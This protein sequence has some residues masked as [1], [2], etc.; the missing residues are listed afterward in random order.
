MKKRG[1]GIAA[2]FYPTGMAGGGDFSHAIVKVKPDG[3]ADLII[4]TSELGQGALTV[5]AQMAAEVL[6]IPYAHVKVTNSDTDACPICFGSFA[7]RV[8]SYTGNAVVQAA[9]NARNIFF[10]VAAEL[11]G[12]AADELVAADGVVAVR[13]Q[14]GKT[15]TIEEVAWA[16]TFTYQKF[17]VGNGCYAPPFVRPDPATG[18]CNPLAAAL[19]FCATQVEIEVDTETGVIEVI[20]SKSV[21]DVGRAINPALVDGQIVGGAA[22]GTSWA[23]M[24]QLYPHYPSHK[25]QARSFSDYMIA[26]AM[27]VP[28]LESR[29]V[30]CPSDIGPFGAKGPGEMV[31]NAPSPAIVNAVRDALGI[32]ITD[33]PLTP[34][35]V[36]RALE[37]HEKKTSPV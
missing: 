7:S 23:L 16:A 13:G 25:H 28:K 32:W 14:P 4:G 30:E 10:E 3:T 22:M 37:E 8:T 1:K 2:G 11:L 24:E 9:E 26:T 12:C 5:L 36:L 18:E 20:D 35:K 29:I 6:G 21:Y 33:I 27:D 31:A 17:I 19:A 34:E 15:K